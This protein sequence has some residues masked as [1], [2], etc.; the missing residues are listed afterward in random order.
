MAFQ[1]DCD[2][3]V[4]V[5]DLEALEAFTPFATIKK[6]KEFKK[7]EE[8]FAKRMKADEINLLKLIIS[9]P[10]PKTYTYQAISS[11]KKVKGDEFKFVWQ[12]IRGTNS[13]RKGVPKWNMCTVTVADGKIKNVEFK[14]SPVLLKQYEK[15]LKK[16]SKSNETLFDLTDTANELSDAYEHLV[17]SIRDVRNTC[18]L[19]ERLRTARKVHASLEAVQLFCGDDAT[20]TVES[21]TDRL[22]TLWNNVKSY[23]A[24]I[25]NKCNDT[26]GTLEKWGC[27]LDEA[28]KAQTSLGVP[29][30]GIDNV[31]GLVNEMSTLVDSACDAHGAPSYNGALEQMQHMF[32]DELDTYVANT[33]EE[34]TGA[35][36]SCLSQLGQVMS[37]KQAADGYSIGCGDNGT[38]S[39]VYASY[40]G[41]KTTLTNR[42]KTIVGHIAQLRSELPDVDSSIEG[43][44]GFGRKL[45]LL[46]ADV[47]YSLAKVKT[48][49]AA[50]TQCNTAMESYLTASSD[51]D[52]YVADEG[53]ISTIRDK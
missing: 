39:D 44:N 48:I 36:E 32:K 24:I 51:V 45:A 20:V 30:T 14:K 12:I 8:L 34:L 33:V 52:V 21:V 23:L 22:S 35:T 27:Q 1:L 17:G 47:R 5:R 38:T 50:L 4:R 3:L 2:T 26:I 43:I 40:N 10:A 42:Y 19:L 53:H 31:T 6:S 11:N 49:K 46:G 9:I 15:A 13:Y 29:Y 28:Y 7:T 25:N 16:P 37:A 18:S 41:A